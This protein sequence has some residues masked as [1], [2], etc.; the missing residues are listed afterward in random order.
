MEKFLARLGSPD[1]ISAQPLPGW[2]ENSL[3]KLQAHTSTN[4]DIWIYDLTQVRGRADLSQPNEQNRLPVWS[5]DGNRIVFSSAAAG[6]LQIYE[7]SVSGV[8]A[9]K[10]VSPSEGH[11]YATTWSPD[12]QF[13][14]GFQENRNTAAYNSLC[15]QTC[16][17]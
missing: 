15:Y 16:G 2:P 5:P 17:R 1:F 7:K 13:I 12:G 14:A 9:E 6:T 8:G 11:R 4:S 10:W 3:S